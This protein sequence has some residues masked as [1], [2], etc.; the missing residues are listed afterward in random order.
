MGSFLLPSGLHTLANTSPQ[1]QKT[2]L[3]FSLNIVF[4]ENAALRIDT[5]VVPD[6]LL[7]ALRR[8][9]QNQQGQQD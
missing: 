2:F 9:Q 6:G 3:F 4:S 7:G 5:R 1:R 8:G